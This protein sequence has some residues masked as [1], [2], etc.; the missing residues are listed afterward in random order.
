MFKRKPTKQRK[1][2]AAS[3][4]KQRKKPKKTKKRTQKRKKVANNNKNTQKKRFFCFVLQLSPVFLCNVVF[5]SSLA[6]L[7]F[8]FLLFGCFVSKDKKKKSKKN[9]Y[10]INFKKRDSWLSYINT[11]L[12]VF[13]KCIYFP[14]HCTRKSPIHFMIWKECPRHDII[15]QTHISKLLPSNIK[16]R[17]QIFP[18]K[19]IAN[20]AN[21]QK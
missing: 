15:W 16:N 11:W 17:Y 21:D 8:F 2:K 19:L 12:V 18:L 3:K 6:L 10:L 20:A 1:N 9:H 7:T 5:S 14:C 13:I 4:Q